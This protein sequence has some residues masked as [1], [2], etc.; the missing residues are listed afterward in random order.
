MAEGPGIS[1]ESKGV[2]RPKNNLTLA[3]APTRL[4]LSYPLPTAFRK[5]SRHVRECVPMV[6]IFLEVIQKKW[7]KETG[8]RKEALDIFHLM[9][10][11]KLARE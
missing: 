11:R 4:C 8:A 2:N 5:H 6:H 9:V 1:G 10:A 7:N 3:A